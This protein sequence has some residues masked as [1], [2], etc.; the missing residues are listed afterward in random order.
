MDRFTLDGFNLDLRHNNR[1][2]EIFDA[3]RI[4]L[5]GSLE[6]RNNSSIYDFI[7]KERPG[8]LSEILMI[9]YQMGYEDGREE[10]TRQAMP[11]ITADEQDQD[12]VDTELRESIT[13]KARLRLVVDN[14]RNNPDPEPPASMAVGQLAA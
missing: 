8:F 6:C 1:I 3:Y 11:L 14:T 10:V 12:Y 9:M 7:Y 13:G 5:T 4:N 2:N